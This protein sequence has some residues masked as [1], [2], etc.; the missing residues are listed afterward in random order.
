MQNEYSILACGRVYNPSDWFYNPAYLVNRIYYISGGTAFY[1]NDILLKPGFLYIFRADPDFRVRQ[2]EEDPVDHTYFDFLTFK[3]LINTDFIEIDLS[4][5]PNLRHLV[6][7]MEEDFR[8]AI[9]MKVA[10]AYLDLLIHALKGYLLPDIHYSE[11]TSAVLKLLH[12]MPADELCVNRIAEQINKNVNHVIRC[13][14]KELG[15]TPH[16]Y[17]AMLKTDLAI[18]CLRQDMA[19]TEI[20]EKLGFCSLSAFSCF[21]K[22]ETGKNLTDFRK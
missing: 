19:C 14:K 17:I 16:K 3:R 15:M 21:F 7:A 20:A 18:S 22:K 12:E 10:H 13:F 5:H 6:H 4:L 2:S 11:T 1:K 9:P 8:H